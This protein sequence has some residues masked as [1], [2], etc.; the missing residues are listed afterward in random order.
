VGPRIGEGMTASSWSGGTMGTPSVG[1]S[2][3]VLSPTGIE[4][5][6]SWARPTKLD[7]LFLQTES[8]L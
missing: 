6:C 7:F 4:P 1:I 3:L 2:D 8:N 5:L